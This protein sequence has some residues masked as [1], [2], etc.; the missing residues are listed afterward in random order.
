MAA[1][2]NSEILGC[3]EANGGEKVDAARLEEDAE[4]I[5]WSVG[6][7]ERNNRFMVGKDEVWCPLRVIKVVNG[8][9]DLMGWRN[10]VI[11]SLL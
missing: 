8:T 1:K 3:E 10:I 9:R 4:R 5:K 11:G 6:Q 7:I 2:Q